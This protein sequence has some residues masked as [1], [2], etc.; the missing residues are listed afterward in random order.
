VVDLYDNTPVPYNF[1]EQMVP[2]FGP[3]GDVIVR[4]ASYRLQ[5]QEGLMNVV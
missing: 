4:A 3:A 1:W 2:G 5:P